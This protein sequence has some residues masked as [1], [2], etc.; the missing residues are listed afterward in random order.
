MNDILI[1]I[2]SMAMFAFA[3]SATPGP[4]NIVSAMSGARFGPLRSLPYVLGA[5]S[6]FV[7]ILLSVGAGLGAFITSY[8]IV[9]KVMAIVGSSYMLYLAYKIAAS[10]GINSYDEN[11]DIPPGFSSG[12][13]AQVS[14]PKAWIVSL[15]A[16]SIYISTSDNYVALLAL[17]SGLFYVICAFSL[18]GWTFVGSKL[19]EHIV[20]FKVFNLVMAAVLSISIAF[21]LI[22]FLLT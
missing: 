13:I 21:F 17:F 18:W 6:G 4:V 16:V 20:D 11:I 12:I 2:S 14:N 19:S 22:D 3:T 15:S 5:T 9:A 1:T 8:S 10:S 7:A